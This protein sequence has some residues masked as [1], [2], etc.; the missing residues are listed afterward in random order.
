MYKNTK[1]IFLDQNELLDKYPVLTIGLPK[2]TRNYFL[3]LLEKDPK[4]C[5]VAFIPTTADPE[6]DKWFVEQSRNELLEL[7]FNVED[8]DLK[9][10]EPISIFERL[11]ARDIVYVNSGNTYYLLYWIKRSGIDQCIGELLDHGIVYVDTS[12]GS[13]VAGPNISLAGWEPDGDVNGV[14][15]KDLQGMNLVDF[16]ISP[17]FQQDSLEKLQKRKKRFAYKV[18]ALTDS[19]AIKVVGKK[20]EIVGPGEKIILD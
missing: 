16:A 5:R 12:A 17:H 3:K 15:I 20:F 18:I 7:G 6:E 9:N 8:V 14:R 2:E 1:S 13:I 10:F 11:K 19:Q 4:S